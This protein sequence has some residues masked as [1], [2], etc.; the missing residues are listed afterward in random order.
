MLQLLVKWRRSKQE[1]S[2]VY[3][4]DETACYS[5]AREVIWFLSLFI[6][7][8]G[9]GARWWFQRISRPRSDWFTRSEV[10]GI[11]R[12]WLVVMPMSS[13]VGFGVKCSSLSRGDAS[14]IK[15]QQSTIAISAPA[16]IINHRRRRMSFSGW[17]HSDGN[18]H[19]IY[20]NRERRLILY[21]TFVI[22]TNANDTTEKASSFG[23]ALL[24]PSL[25]LPAQHQ[26]TKIF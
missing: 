25:S 23:S 21:A 26:H 2:G 24:F 22:A 4:S 11:R 5:F 15:T 3:V 14:E 13:L 1:K 9:P 12:G 19:V 17:R 7:T 18:H 10:E 6:F 16:M 8:L 20:P